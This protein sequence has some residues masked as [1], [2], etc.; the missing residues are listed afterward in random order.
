MRLLFLF[1]IIVLLIGCRKDRGPT[2]IKAQFLN[3]C[4]GA[5]VGGEEVKVVATE[6]KV[7][8]LE[9]D[10]YLV[11]ETG[12]FADENGIV[13]FVF[14]PITLS[15][16]IRLYVQSGFLSEK[17]YEESLDFGTFYKAAPEKYFITLKTD[18]VYQVI[19][20]VFFRSERFSS[21]KYIVQPTNGQL[22]VLESDRY[23]FD[24]DKFLI[25]NN[26]MFFSDQNIVRRASLV[27][28]F[29][30][31]NFN[32]ANSQR[33]IFEFSLCDTILSDT[34]NVDLLK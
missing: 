25:D 29:D 2:K 19:D 30:L 32:F 34:I 16:A 9:T 1:T 33:K 31:N 14:E 28:S 27:A 3:A 13:E 11:F 10:D 26:L 7:R 21:L 8:I 4:D 17:T 22:V 20:T 23:L 6:N 12:A 24:S 5:P 18:S 15:N